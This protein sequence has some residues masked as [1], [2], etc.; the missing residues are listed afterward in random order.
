[1]Q[2]RCIP[3]AGWHYPLLRHLTIAETSMML[4]VPSI[5]SIAPST[6]TSAVPLSG[7]ASLIVTEFVAAT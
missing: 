1:M 3:K 4:V 7:L 6:I 5:A 2:P